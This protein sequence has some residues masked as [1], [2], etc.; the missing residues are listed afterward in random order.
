M[1]DNFSKI[2]SFNKFM[3]KDEWLI[4]ESNHRGEADR[5]MLVNPKAEGLTPDYWLIRD[6]KLYWYSTMTNERSRD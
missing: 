4:G 2:N 5:L 3:V 1:S 6:Y